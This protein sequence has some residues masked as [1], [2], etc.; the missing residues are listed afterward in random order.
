MQ[1]CFRF[2]VLH[3]SATSER[4]A[5]DIFLRQS[6]HHIALS[7]ESCSLVWNVDR[8]VLKINKE[9]GKPR[10]LSFLHKQ[11][12]THTLTTYSNYQIEF[13]VKDIYVENFHRIPQIN[14]YLI[15]K[16]FNCI[17]FCFNLF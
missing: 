12:R 3:G 4:Y 5:G 6:G 9:V 17:I 1:Q 16:R 11:K 15:R 7:N 2:Q 8:V 13:S 14:K 10:S